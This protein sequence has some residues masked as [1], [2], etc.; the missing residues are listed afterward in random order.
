M[1]TFWQP[2]GLQLA[3]LPCPSLSSTVCSDSCS[4]S[5]W[6]YLTISSSAAPFFFCLKSFPASGSFQMSW[7]FTS[8]GQSIGNSA[9][10]SVLLPKNTLRIDWFDLLAV[11]GTLKSLLQSLLHNLKASFLFFFFL[12]FCH[13]WTTSM[14]YLVVHLWQKKERKIKFITELSK[15]IMPFTGWP[16]LCRKPSPGWGTCRVNPWNS[17][18]LQGSAWELKSISILIGQ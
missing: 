9:S 17:S 18:G 11:Q 14:A 1:F 8:D 4:M 2:H 13:I 7:L 12:F 10:A 5:W 16:F 15:D 6:C 3:R